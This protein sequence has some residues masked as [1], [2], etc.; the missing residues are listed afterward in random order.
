MVDLGEMPA[1]EHLSAGEEQ[2]RLSATKPS[3]PSSSVEVC[4]SGERGAVS[5]SSKSDL[6]VR[7][8]NGEAGASRVGR[9]RPTR[10][11]R[12]RKG[13]SM[14]GEE[15]GRGVPLPNLSGSSCRG[16]RRAESRWLAHGHGTGIRGSPRT[17]SCLGDER[18]ERRVIGRADSGMRGRA[19][20]GGAGSSHRGL[21][22]GGTSDIGIELY[23][24]AGHAARKFALVSDWGSIFSASIGSRLIRGSHGLG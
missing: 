20:S 7:S 23:G 16:V 18:M 9:S 10:V 14:G 24:G 11:A 5:S 22:E 19:R 1:L 15:C 4:S 17:P 12:K 6:I 21:S 13:C 3:K 2:L 8:F